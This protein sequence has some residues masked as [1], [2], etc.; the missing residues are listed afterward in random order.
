[1]SITFPLLSESVSSIFNSPVK[2]AFAAGTLN[3]T[4][5]TNNGIIAS[6]AYVVVSPLDNF[7]VI[8]RFFSSFSVAFITRIEAHFSSFSPLITSGNVKSRLVN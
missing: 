7:A 8:T 5:L 6:V 4:F 1:M 3:F 2:S